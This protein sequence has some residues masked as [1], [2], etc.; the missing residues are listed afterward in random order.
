MPPKLKAAGGTQGDKDDVE[1]LA[2]RMEQ[3][4]VSH[5]DNYFGHPIHGVQYKRGRSKATAADARPAGCAAWHSDA[6]ASYPPEFTQKTIRLFPQ[7]V[8]GAAG[9]GVRVR[10]GSDEAISIEEWN[11]KVTAWASKYPNVKDQDGDTPHETK[12]FRGQQTNKPEIVRACWEALPNQVPSRY[13]GYARAALNHFKSDRYGNVVCLRE[14]VPGGRANDGA[15]SF[16]DVDHIFP[17]SRGGRSRMDNFE[18][19]QCSANRAVKCDNMVQVVPS[20][21]PNT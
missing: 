12:E 2:K 21:N 17:W 4:S 18:A 3:V 14:T 9:G 11:A 16:F 10:W 19:V 6:A 13:T 7:A 5:A 20:S 1:V 8:A 15:L